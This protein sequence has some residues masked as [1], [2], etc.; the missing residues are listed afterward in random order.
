[1]NEPFSTGKS[2]A[3]GGLADLSVA[4]PIMRLE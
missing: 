2:V 3:S 4:W 1:M